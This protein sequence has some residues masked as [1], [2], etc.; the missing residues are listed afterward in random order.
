MSKFLPKAPPGWEKAKSSAEKPLAS[1]SAIAN[2][3]PITK[4]TVV[5]V[6]GASP[7]GHASQV[8]W[9]SKCASAA[10]DKVESGSPVMQIKGT[11]IRL[12]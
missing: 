7:R 12:I 3:S 5:L 9:T 8:T 11:P 2:A 6:V 10:L 1:S 4:V